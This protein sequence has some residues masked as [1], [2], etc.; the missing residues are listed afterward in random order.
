MSTRSPAIDT[1]INNA[2]DFAKPILKHLRKVVHAGCPQVEET[3]KWRFPHFMYKGMFCGMAAFKEH[4]T[5]GFWKG[6]L[7]VK[8]GDD[9]G[10]GQFGKIRLLSDLPDEKTLL[11]YVREAVRLNDEG[12]KAPRQIRPKVKKPLLVPEYL[13]AVLKRNAK[14]RETFENF[15]YSHKKE[16]V[17]WV[18]EAKQEETRKRRLETALEWMS[19][20]KTRHWK[21]ANC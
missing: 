12:V 8:N 2:A 21:Y 3:L 19:E 18:T 11:K 20:G 16:Y 10:M 13:T 15:S 6:D 9:E 7:I 17:E 5:F 14:A 1:Y 4:C